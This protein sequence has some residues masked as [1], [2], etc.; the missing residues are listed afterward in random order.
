[1]IFKTEKLEKL[2]EYIPELDEYIKLHG[3]ESIIDSL[4]GLLS[5]ISNHDKNW[6]LL[7]YH[8][9]NDGAFIFTFKMV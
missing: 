7:Q 5:I 1:M 6:E 3:E 8:I 4:D 2:R 9:F